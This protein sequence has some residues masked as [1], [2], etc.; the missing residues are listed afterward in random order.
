MG[1]AVVV[2]A[3]GAEPARSQAAAPRLIVVVVV[4]QMRADYLFEFGRHW[5]RGFRTLLAEG[6]VFENAAYPYLKTVTCAGHATI[7]TGTFPRTHGIIDNV[8]WDREGAALVDCSIDPNPASAHISYGAAVASGNGPHLLRAQTL[9]DHLRAQR[10]GAKVVTLSLKPD[11]SVMLGGHGGEAV[12]WFDGPAGAFVTSGA[13]AQGRHPVVASFLAAN[14]ITGD[15][16]G[17]W[18]L[19]NPVDTY[20]H[21]DATPGQ[22][23]PL[24]RD[25]LFPHDIAGAAGPDARSVGFWMQSPRSDRYVGRMA[26]WIADQLD[27]GT[28]Q[29]PDLLA[30]GFS[31]LDLVG[32]AF[33]PE[34]RE[35]EDILINLDD[36]IGSLIDE[37][38][39]RVGRANYVLGLTA[40]HG[41]API[42]SV[43]GGGWIVAEDIEDR[44][45]D[46]LRERWGDAPVGRH[47]LVRTGQV[48]FA[49]GVS[50]RL[51]ADRALWNAV[52]DAIDRFPGVARVLDAAILSAASGDAA[53]R[54]A[55]LSYVNGRSGDLVILTER[56]WTLGGRV[57]GVAATHG[58]MHDYDRRV[59]LILFGGAVRAGRMSQPATPADLAPTLSSLAGIR[60][61]GAEGR[62]LNEALK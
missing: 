1:L 60:L 39:R 58:T 15:M 14:P 36:T 26:Q 25:G 55:A 12:I 47:L 54:A 31:A 38:D 61:P 11:T 9:G 17:T 57:V 40:D 42:P 33:G 45:E 51:R 20:T 2:L 53:V 56:N 21:P 8:W 5:R 49:P 16:R 19:R 13:F 27:L 62:I 29:Q 4:D 32:H 41:V 50:Q 35:V 28:D 10:A 30:I 23:P 43:S 52:I 22:R 24:G 37:L 34:S 44:V 3:S 7:A 6:A 59:P 48:F 46:M 18:S